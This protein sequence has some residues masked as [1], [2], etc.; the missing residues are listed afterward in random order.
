MYTVTYA[1]SNSCRIV[2]SNRV[3]SVCEAAMR[4]NRYQDWR[5][6]AG[7]GLPRTEPMAATTSTPNEPQTCS[8]TGHSH[9]RACRQHRSR[10]LACFE[11]TILSLILL[12]NFGDYVQHGL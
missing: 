8:A 2:D 11:L 12:L 5:W 7:R 4:N 9:R 1:A 6:T 3:S 10:S